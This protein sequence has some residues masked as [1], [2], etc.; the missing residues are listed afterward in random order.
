[1]KVALL[2][3]ILLAAH[4]ALSVNNFSATDTTTV[5]SRNNI[6]NLHKT[7]RTEVYASPVLTWDQVLANEMGTYLSTCVWGHDANRSTG[8]TAAVGENIYA[9]SPIVT[10]DVGLT[11][12][13]NSWK[14]EKAY[15]VNNPINTACTGGQ[16]CGH[17]SQMV[18]K[19]STTIGC[20]Y[21]T[22]ATATN[23]AGWTNIV[24]VGCRYYPAGN[25]LNQKA[26]AES[27]FES[28]APGTLNKDGKI[29]YMSKSGELIPQSPVKISWSLIAVGVAVVALTATLVA[30]LVIRRRRA[31]V[32]ET[33]VELLA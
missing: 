10:A 7:T 1:M 24:L 26:F 12:A 19:A 27:D 23:L 18:W 32:P 6:V 11:E 22:C 31:P 33:Q 2:C 30:V 13:H 16:V 4:A 29:Y 21:A 5:A 28:F 14:A 15:F 3:A 9:R 17:Y 8:H 20:A 25:Y